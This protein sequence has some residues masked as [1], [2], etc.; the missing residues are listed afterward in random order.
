MGCSEKQ[1]K[2]SKKMKKAIVFFTLL[3]SMNFA[4]RVLAQEPLPEPAADG[5][6]IFLEG[7]LGFGGCQGDCDNVDPSLGISLGGFFKVMPNVAAGANIRYQMYGIDNGDMSSLMFSA[8]G[9]Y[10]Y[11]L[12]PQMNVYGA[13]A[14]GY[15][16]LS[17]EVDTGFGTVKA[18]D[19]AYFVQLGAGVEYALSPVM[20][21][22][23]TLRYQLNFWDEMDSDFNDW[24][25][26]VSFGY[27]F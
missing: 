7:G 21:V 16:K 9:R 6:K 3:F 25:L 14:L 27:R 8:E 18:D 1:K 17:M 26:S 11:P 20:F 10:Y 2:R 5:P 19:S 12:N 13:A 15:D 22:G 23:G 24:L 4:S